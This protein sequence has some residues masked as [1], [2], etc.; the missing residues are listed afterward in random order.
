MI[1]I[2]QA[3]KT[4]IEDLRIINEV[5]S[6]HTSCEDQDDISSSPSMSPSENETLTET[7]NAEYLNEKLIK[8]RKII[9]QKSTTISNLTRINKKLEDQNNTLKNT[10]DFL[11][12]HYESNTIGKHFLENFD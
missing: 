5:D 8:Y 7:N 11:L 3:E 2:I 12:N 6:A 10:I 1:L 4:E 9:Q